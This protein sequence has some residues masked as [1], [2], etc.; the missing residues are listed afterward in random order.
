MAPT[1]GKSHQTSLSG[2]GSFT[3]RR[4]LGSPNQLHRTVNSPPNTPARAAMTAR[5]RNRAAN[6]AS[7]AS[8]VRTNHS[9]CRLTERDPVLCGYLRGSPN[10]NVGGHAGIAATSRWSFTLGNQ[11]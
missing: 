4:L 2:R 7:R 1:T 5:R 10:T 3:G 11:F 8:I 6:H 9:A